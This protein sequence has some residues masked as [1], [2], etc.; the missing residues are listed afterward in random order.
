MRW[1][2]R[3]SERIRNGDEYLATAP[4]GKREVFA[5]SILDGAPQHVVRL[6][7]P[8]FVPMFAALA[9]AR[10]FVGVL[11]SVDEASAAGAAAFLL[12]LLVWLWEPLPE[13]NSKDVGQ[14]K[15]L[16]IDIGDQ[17]SPAWAGASISCWSTHRSGR[18]P[19]TSRS[20]TR[21]R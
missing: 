4:E 13:K 2:R 8:T 15:R 12:V 10:V 1:W 11:L 16:P 21:P 7:G 3:R 20:S 14:G 6:P 18:H 9:T 17:T 19:A 5:T